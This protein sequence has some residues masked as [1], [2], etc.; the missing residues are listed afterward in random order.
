MK[1]VEVESGSTK[2]LPASAQAA[3][4]KFKDAARKVK[5]LKEQARQAKLQLK[6]A[7]QMESNGLLD[8]RDFR[9]FT[10]TGG[11]SAA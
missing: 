2:D 10:R 3:E 11:C 5:G 1:I 4:R 7:K 8:R 9:A 6:R